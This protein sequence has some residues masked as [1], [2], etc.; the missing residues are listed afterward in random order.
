MKPAITLWLLLLGLLILA[1]PAIAQHPMY[2]SDRMQITVRVSPDNDARVLEK[3][4]PNYF[5]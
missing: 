3:S 4:L 5:L 2:V 1:E